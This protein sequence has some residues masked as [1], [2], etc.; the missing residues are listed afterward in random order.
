MSWM[1]GISAQLGGRNSPDRHFGH[2]DRRPRAAL[3]GPSEFLGSGRALIDGPNNSVT[4]DAWHSR[5]EADSDLLAFYGME[6]RS[7]TD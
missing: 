1:T 3:T 6:Q 2:Q 4:I 7:V 5:L